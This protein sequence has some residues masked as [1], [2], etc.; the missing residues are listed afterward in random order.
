[1]ARPQFFATISDDGTSTPAPDRPRHGFFPRQLNEGWRRRD[2]SEK[3]E[4]LR[5][6]PKIRSLQESA[7]DA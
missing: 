6:N 5:G 2:G 4:I 3:K 7:G 1:M